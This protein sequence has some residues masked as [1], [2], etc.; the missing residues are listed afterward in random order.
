MPEVAWRHSGEMPP[1]YCEECSPK[2]NRHTKVKE[3]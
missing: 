3:E 2:D 1:Y